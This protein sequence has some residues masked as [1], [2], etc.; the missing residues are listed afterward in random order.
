MAQLKMHRPQASA[1]GSGLCTGETLALPFSLQQT[2]QFPGQEEACSGGRELWGREC[3]TPADVHLFVPPMMDFR[4]FLS[5]ISDIL[6][7]HPNP[8][9][10]ST[11]QS[12][13]D[14]MV[15]ESIT[16]IVILLYILR[17]YRN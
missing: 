16:G 6:H 15:Y 14:F 2:I 13:Q 17:E 3:L 8:D 10:T 5:L 11:S 1:L 7:L 4:L 12:G 9:S